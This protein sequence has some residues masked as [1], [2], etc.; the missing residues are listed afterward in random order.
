[1]SWAGP[2]YAHPTWMK[3]TR[4]GKVMSAFLSEDGTTWTLVDTV[5]ISMKTDVYMGI[6]LTSHNNLVSNTS[7]FQNLKFT[8]DG[9]SGS[10]SGSGSGGGGSALPCQAPGWQ[11]SDVGSVGLPGSACYDSN[12]KQ[13]E[14]VASGADIWG[15]EDQFGFVYRELVGD[16][17]VS[18][19]MTK[20]QNTHTYAKG[21]LMIREDLSTNSKHAMIVM[22]QT[23][24]AFQYRR[25]K[26]AATAPASGS[27]TGPTYAHPTWMK[28]TRVG[29]VISSFL[30]EDGNSWSLV[31]TVQIS[32][33]TNVY[34]GIALTSHNNLI[35]NTST[36]DNIVFS[37][38]AAASFPVELLDFQAEPA[39]LGVQLLWKTASELN[40][41]YFTVERSGDGSI[42]EI[43]SHVNGEGTSST[44]SEYVTMDEDPLD[45]LIYYRL[46]QTD[47]DGVKTM[48]STITYRNEDNFDD[49]F[50]V[51]PN[52]VTGTTFSLTTF[53][54]PMEITKR[55]RVLDANGREILRSTMSGTDG[56]VDLPA[57]L[58]T[59]VY[60]VMIDYQGG[61]LG[62]SIIIE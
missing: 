24:R 49:R 43:L 4:V 8:G 50:E 19:Q 60:H 17:E 52:P 59:G 47:F 32:M 28:M 45:G 36:F 29:N 13:W 11:F 12:T 20:L 33:K 9:G 26:G 35:Y 58:P 37:G 51:Y 31:D 30:S 3:M 55:I 6:A 54:I 15:S 34:V 10:G 40:N 39:T 56:S 42:F 25:A 22:N 21:G 16:G 44:I 5:H 18:M 57:N 61:I 48:L 41:N 62:K 53:G 27:W 38:E 46:S 23:K 14:I 2:T 7:T 1:G